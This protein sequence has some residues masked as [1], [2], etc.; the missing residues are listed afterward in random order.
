MTLIPSLAWRACEPARVVGMLMRPR[1]GVGPTPPAACRG[2][3]GTPPTVLLPIP[4]E[5]IHQL[6]AAPRSPPGGRS[7]PR[8]SAPPPRFPSATAGAGPSP[9]APALATPTRST[10][11]PCSAP[12]AAHVTA[13]RGCRRPASA[14]GPRP[15]DPGRGARRLRGCL[16]CGRP[17][18]GPGRRR[19]ARRPRPGARRRGACPGARPVSRRRRGRRACPARGWPRGRTACWRRRSSCGPGRSSGSVPGRCPGLGAAGSRPGDRCGRS[20]G[21][22]TRRRRRRGPG[23]A[24]ALDFAYVLALW[25]KR[26]ER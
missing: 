11:A 2:P 1:E 23:L 12:S 25:C 21:V 4:L 7:S 18:A 20:G 6:T 14:R 16:L 13:S 15:P 22:R 9:S 5:T 8:R 10:E 19:P 26:L 24:P 3:S 17:R